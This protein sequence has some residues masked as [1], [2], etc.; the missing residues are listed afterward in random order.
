MDGHE[1]QGAAPDRRHG[2]RKEPGV[3]HVA[4]WF[5]H[6][7]PLASPSWRS[8]SQPERGGDDRRG[9][10]L[11][12]PKGPGGSSSYLQ[13]GTTTASVPC[14]TSPRQGEWTWYLHDHRRYP[15][16]TNPEAPSDF[17]RRPRPN[18]NTHS[19]N[20]GGK[21]TIRHACVPSPDLDA[22]AYRINARGRRGYPRRPLLFSRSAETRD[23]SS[24]PL[25][26]LRS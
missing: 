6:L 18:H 19:R 23:Y 10:G 7:L 24:P 4:P 2:I 20:P 13:A 3:R 5:V 1:R 21:D 26:K 12:Q 8:R 17:R 11:R 22:S 14:T 15:R 25:Q 16:P 9:H